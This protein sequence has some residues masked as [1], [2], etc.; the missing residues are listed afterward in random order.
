MVPKLSRN[1]LFGTYKCLNTQMVPKL[2]SGSSKSSVHFS[3]NF[4]GKLV[5]SIRKAKLII[6]KKSWL[7]SLYTV[8]ELP[9]TISSPPDHHWPRDRYHSLS[10]LDLF[11]L[12]PIFLI[13]AK[14]RSSIS[15]FGKIDRLYVV[16]FEALFTAN[17]TPP[18]S[19]INSSWIGREI[20]TKKLNKRERECE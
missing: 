17:L 15:F 10:L 2:S 13:N 4:E 5:N 18:A 1:E 11:I 9:P 16:G 7:L 8:P 20:K 6:K 19:S 14:V 12:I 3:V